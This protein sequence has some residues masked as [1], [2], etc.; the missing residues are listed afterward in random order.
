[1]EPRP[2]KA[3]PKVQLFHACL[4]GMKNYKHSKSEFGDFRNLDE[5]HSSVDKLHSLFVDTLKWDPCD[6]TVYKDSPIYLSQ[7]FE[8]IQENIKKRKTVSL[9]NTK[10]QEMTFN[11]FA[12][13][14]HGF[15]DDKD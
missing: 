2:E 8:K 7:L 13:V 12:F 14:G 6:V 1:M 9:E 5:S 4:I 10:P 11:V 3:Q 15:I